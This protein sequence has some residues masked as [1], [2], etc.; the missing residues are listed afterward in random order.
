[1]S[2]TNEAR[3]TEWHET[4]KC[5]LD[6]SACNDKQRWN[7][8]KLIDKGRCDKGFILNPSILECECDKSCDIGQYSDYENC[9]CRKEL[10]SKFVEEC[11]ETIDGNEM[12]YNATLNDHK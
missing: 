5:T 6:A 1:M 2:K 12:V 10:I 8:E 7:N 11:S 3:H 4:C 9:K